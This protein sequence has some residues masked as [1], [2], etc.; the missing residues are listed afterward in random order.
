MIHPARRDSLE[1]E[2]VEAFNA[3]AANGGAGD[4]DRD[5]MGAQGLL[6]SGQRRQS[7]GT[8]LGAD[9]ILVVEHVTRQR[10]RQR[11]ENLLGAPGG[12]HVLSAGLGEQLILHYQL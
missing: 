7:T 12:S 10:F 5:R 8:D 9:S 11:R 1:T 4:F 2:S 6:A 3:F